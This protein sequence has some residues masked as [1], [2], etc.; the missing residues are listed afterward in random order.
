M[1][2]GALLLP[3]GTWPDLVRRAQET[4]ALGFDFVWVD[5]HAMHPARPDAPWFEAWTALAGLAAETWRVRLGPLVSNVVLRHPVVLARQARTVE[6]IAGGRLEVGLGAG[7]APSD[8]AALGEPPW[9][10]DER[11]ERFAE[12]VAVIDALLR[13]E[14]A[15]VDGEHYRVEEMVL[16]PQPVGDKRPPLA[17]AAHGSRALGVAARHGDTWVSY[18]GF[19]LDPDEVLRRTRRRLAELERACEAIGRDPQTV[20]RRL[21][22][23]SGA[24]T[25]DPIWTSVDAFGEFAGRL[26]EAGV[27]ELALH[28]P[29]AAVNPPGAVRDGIVAE[30]ADRWFAPP[31]A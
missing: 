29:P 17:I 18:G 30:I 20:R 4:E 3:T 26:Q 25:R 21:L 23:G 28:Y 14:P 8:H 2:F 16:A 6:Q 19:G 12:A 7:Y 24:L 10:A 15:T 27:D 13:G 31:A 22:A 5:D 11:A 9:P 1:R